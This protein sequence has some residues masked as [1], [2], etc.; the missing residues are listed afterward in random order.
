MEDLCLPLVVIQDV[1]VVVANCPHPVVV[2][3]IAVPPEVQYPVGLVVFYL[4]QEE[5]SLADCHTREAF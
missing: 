1:S 5:S 2:L 3:S 4:V